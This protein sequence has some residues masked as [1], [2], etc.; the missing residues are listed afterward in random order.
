MGDAV[1]AIALVSPEHGQVVLPA[2]AEPAAEGVKAVRA[3]GTDAPV[4]WKRG[5]NGLEVVLPAGWAGDHGYALALE[6]E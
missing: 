5:P 1:Y 6:L 2:F 4:V 3:L